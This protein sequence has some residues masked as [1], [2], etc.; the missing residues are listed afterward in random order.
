MRRQ[1]PHQGAQKSTTTVRS[2]RRTSLSNVASVTWVIVSLSLTGFSIR[3]RCERSIGGAEAGSSDGE[4]PSQAAHRGVR[5][6]LHG[7]ERHLQAVGDLALREAVEVEQGEKLPLL[8]GKTTQRAPGHGALLVGQGLLLG[9][10][11]RRRLEL[12]GRDR[13]AA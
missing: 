11:D 4:R 13:A 1:G 10:P 2:E 12:L 3:R 5:A 7:A 9:R 6:A 8:G